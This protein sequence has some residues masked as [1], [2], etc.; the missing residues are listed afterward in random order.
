MST[1]RDPV[2]VAVDGTWGSTG[3]ISFAADEAHRRG[4]ALVVAHVAPAVVPFLPVLPMSEDEV[5]S[6]G[7]QTLD[8]A[9]SAVRERRPELDVSTLLRIGSRVRHLV[10][11]AETS[12]LVVLG[13][14]LSVPLERVL[15]GSVSTR[16][17]AR[18]AR[19]CV[20]VPA[21]WKALGPDEPRQVV[22][23]LG[24]VHGA[25]AVLSEAFSVA[26]STGAALRVM[27]TWHVPDAYGELILASRDGDALL[28]T[29]RERFDALL[30]PWRSR[31]P[32][33][34]VALDVEPGR[35]V[36]V[37]MAA[38]RGAERLVIGRTTPGS[39]SR[40]LGS[41]GLGSTAHALILSAPSPVVVVP[42]DEVAHDD[43]LV[44]EERGHLVR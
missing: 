19:P 5:A 10:E 14:D 25:D 26:E 34:D 31:H 24:S 17:T 38:S 29:V 41:L 39:R 9:A 3:A 32:Q 1:G 28:A 44:L 27:H 15:T 35:P 11:L 22:A 23:G 21:A 18:A 37:L 6:V 20:V 12:S 8:D 40:G 2:L 43:E 13:R 4:V 36:H 42:H 33:V 30:A 7:Q 16:V